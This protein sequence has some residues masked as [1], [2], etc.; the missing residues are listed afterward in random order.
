MAQE[1]SASLTSYRKVLTTISSDVLLP[2]K[3]G[4]PQIR[5]QRPWTFVLRRIPLSLKRLHQ[6]LGV[7]PSIGPNRSTWTTLPFPGIF[8]FRPRPL[9]YYPLSPTCRRYS[10][11]LCFVRPSETSDSFPSFVWEILDVHLGRGVVELESDPSDETRSRKVLAFQY[12]NTTNSGDA[13]TT[14]QCRRHPLIV[15]VVT[16]HVTPP[17]S[18]W[19]DRS[20]KRSGG[21]EVQDLGDPRSLTEGKST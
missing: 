12:L 6:F 18:G 16:T 21:F 10:P 14:R 17:N 3:Q 2:G 1:E 9:D 20:R 15:S 4:F 19:S 7:Y 5:D 11:V 8:S 13:D